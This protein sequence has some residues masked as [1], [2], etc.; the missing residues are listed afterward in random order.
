MSEQKENENAPYKI[1]FEEFLSDK[2]VKSLINYENWCLST[3]QICWKHSQ[4]EESLALKLQIPQLYS[5][6]D[7]L[8]LWCFTPGLASVPV[9]PSVPSLSLFSSL[10]SSIPKMFLILLVSL[11]CT[12]A[13]V[14][15]SNE[16]IPPGN[17]SWEIIKNALWK[18]RGMEKYKSK[19]VARP[20]CRRLVDF[21]LDL[22]VRCLGVD[23]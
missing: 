23:Q 22:T 21:F 6:S 5:P 12:F 8:W 10:S 20:S 3:F 13:P 14:L 4:P 9:S 18:K 11:L 17:E 1:T 7:Q 19:K 2:E 15:P 16:I